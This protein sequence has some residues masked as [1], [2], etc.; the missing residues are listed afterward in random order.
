MTRKIQ[1]AALGVAALVAVYVLFFSNIFAFEY[2][3]EAA[4]LIRK[5]SPL[6]ALNTVDYDRRLL[7]LA[8]VQLSTTTSPSAQVAS[9][10]PGRL[11]PVKAVYPRTGAI[12]PFKRILAFYGNF[13]SRNMGVLGEHPDDELVKKLE[14]EALVWAAADPTTPVLPA[15]QYIAVVAQGTAGREGKYIL[16]MPDE[17]IDH[18]LALAEQVHGIVILDLQV[19]L[20]TL[21]YELPMLEKY[22]SLPQVHLA[23]DPEFSMK[24]GNRPGT[25]IGTYDATDINYAARY[26]AELVREHELPPKVLL[27]HRFTQHMVTNY[28]NIRPLPEVQ[29]IM[30]MDGWGTQAKKKGTYQRVITPEPVQFAGIKLFYKNDRKPPSTGLLTPSQ[31]LSLMPAPIYIQYQ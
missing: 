27:V 24:S 5:F 3:S 1:I 26:L 29:I 2:R 11:W 17:E 18:A 13:Y 19:G 7:L 22:L 15:I 31:V 25:V 6:P 8:H 14:S 16:R 20:S 9:S 28:Q 21:A 10:R 4:D 12:L 23:I 30:D